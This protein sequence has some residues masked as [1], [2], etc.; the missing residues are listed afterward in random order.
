MAEAPAPSYTA[1]SIPFTSG[2]PCDTDSSISP[3]VRRNI[4]KALREG[5]LLEVVSVVREAMQTASRAPVSIAVTGDSGNGM[6]SFINALR[7]IGHDTEVSAPTG[8]V[9]TTH[10]RACY[11][12]S[13]FPNVELWDL[14]GMGATA[15]SME[16]Y[17]CEM[18]FPQYD[19]IIIIAS[20]QFS[21]NHVHLAKTIKSMGKRFYV[22]WT[23]LD[24]DLSTST[25]SKAQ[26]LQN[27][28]EN[29]RGSLQKEGVQEPPIFLVSS[30]DPLSHDFPKLRDTLQKDLSSIRCCGPLEKLSQ[31]CER[32]IDERVDSM[33][34]KIGTEN[35]NKMS[36]IR[37]PD[38][39]L[40]NFKAL[41]LLFGVDDKSLQQVM[42]SMEK[43]VVE[44]RVARENQDVQ[45][46]Y[47]QESW[48][49]PRILYFALYYFCT[50]L[51]YIPY[52]SDSGVYY[53]RYLEH[54]RLLTQ[55]AE[56]TKVI[57]RKILEESII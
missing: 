36:G 10:T 4:E 52:C 45:S 44:Y 54:R 56:H 28:Q 5:K 53:R 26:L 3:K 8:V 34:S 43:P 7:A 23:K 31:I 22:V 38:N 48:I 41:Q 33:K 51:S 50:G 12:S 19:L 9:R 27:I 1:L 13:S 40:E 49:G 15:Q 35:F 14:P 30:F 24:R 57:L 37:D 2:M 17:M 55:V 16:G 42:Q 39:S 29:I 6:S 25:H 32:I 20:E 11:F 18:Q 47:Y 21:F 46:Y